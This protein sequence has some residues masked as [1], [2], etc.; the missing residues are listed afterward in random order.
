MASQFLKLG[1]LKNIFAPST[2]IM[3]GT[4][5]KYQNPKSTRRIDGP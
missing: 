4:D 5:A 1:K 3:I 2:P